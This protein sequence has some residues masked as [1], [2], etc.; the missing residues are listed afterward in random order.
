[1]ENLRILVTA[2]GG[3]L[4]QAIIKCLR[5]MHPPVFIVGCD[6]TSPNAGESFP[7]ENLIV[8][9]CNSNDYLLT[10]QSICEQYSVDAIIPTCEPEIEWFGKNN[11]KLNCDLDIKIISLPQDYYAVHSDKL[12]SYQS[13]Q[14]HVDLAWF[15]DGN[16]K[17]SIQRIVNE[18]QFP[19]IIKPRKSSGSSGVTM[20]S[21][22]NELFEAIQTVQSPIVQEYTDDTYGEFSV[23]VFISEKCKTAIA[24]RRT[25]GS[26]GASWYADNH[27]QDEEVL[28]YALDVSTATGLQGSG[29]IQVRKS[30][31]GVRLLEINPRFSSLSAARAL[32]GFRD[33]EWSIQL[34]FE[35][36]SITIP[37]QYKPIRFQRFLH[38]VI[39]FGQGYEGIREWYPKSRQK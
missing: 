5:L 37:S 13:L 1:M 17:N 20:A 8:P 30:S 15:I 24:F 33:V 14:N 4:G 34:A 2:I 19:C 35:P 16:N 18:D 7:D 21:N 29:N 31:D 25:L 28:Q 22:K 12:T 27:D 9:P 6:A 32:C 11:D 10:I 36:E 3:D 26:S 23:G 39:D 38:E